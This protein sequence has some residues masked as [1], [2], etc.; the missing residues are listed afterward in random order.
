MPVNYTFNLIEDKRIDPLSLYLLVTRDAC[1]SDRNIIA[2]PF[3]D[4][5]NKQVIITM[6]NELSEADILHLDRIVKHH[7]HPDD[8]EFIS[9]QS[10]P[11]TSNIGCMPT[12]IINNGGK[13][14]LAIENLQQYDFMRA[15]FI[16]LQAD[17]ECLVDIH[18]CH[19]VADTHELALTPD[20][21]IIENVY[22]LKD[23][24]MFLDVTTELQNVVDTKQA[25]ILMSVLDIQHIDPSNPS[26]PSASINVHL[27]GIRMDMY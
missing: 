13:G 5:A 11:V 15:S 22:L 1:L 26:N 17:Q 18:F 25:A 24:L 9:F 4:V 8:A 6:L 14:F 23:T 2:L 10:H 20:E 27:L 3:W 12:T 19:K 7:T 16:G 21:I